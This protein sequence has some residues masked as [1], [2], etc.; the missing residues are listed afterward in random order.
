MIRHIVSW[1]MGAAHPE[2]RTADAEG[3]RQRLEALRGV[4][5][6]ERL[7]VGIDLGATEGNWH[8][9]LVSDFATAEDLAAYQT[10]PQHVHAAAF[11]RSV[12]A[13]RSC[14]DYEI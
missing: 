3:I 5:P 2:Q 9:V 11:I 13:D 1:R 10:H 12:A 14:V 7:E 8:V 4:V 6:A